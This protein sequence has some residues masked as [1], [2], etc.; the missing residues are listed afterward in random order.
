MNVNF[1][2]MTDIYPYLLKQLANKSPSCFYSKKEE[3]K[4]ASSSS[5]RAKDKN[6]FIGVTAIL[7][8]S[9]DL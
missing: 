5:F 2:M 7:P 9:H 4:S 1:A 3:I 8:L 6:E